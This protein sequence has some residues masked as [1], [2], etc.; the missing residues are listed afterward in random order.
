MP[1]FRDNALQTAHQICHGFQPHPHVENMLPKVGRHGVKLGP[2]CRIDIRHSI[3]SCRL[4]CIASIAGRRK[5]D[6]A[7]IKKRA[8][9]TETRKFWSVPTAGSDCRPAVGQ[10]VVR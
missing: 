7:G 5:K 3:T 2:D 8:S 1:L 6:T 9:E 10:W 4:V